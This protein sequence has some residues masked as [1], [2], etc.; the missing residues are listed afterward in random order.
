MKA[1]LVE[2]EQKTA[3]I[4]G[5]TLRL[6]FP[7]IDLICSDK[8]EP[9]LDLLFKEIFDFAII[10]LKLADISGFEFLKR[11]RLFSQVPVLAIQSGL[12]D[13]DLVRAID[14]GADD[15]LP[16][17]VNPIILIARAKALIRRV[18]GFLNR[19]E[20]VAGMLRLDSLIHKAYFKGQEIY[21]TR[22]E[23]IVLHHLMNNAGH[24]ASYR[25]LACQLWGDD[26][27][28]SNKAIRKCIDRLKVKLGTVA[29]SPELINERGVGFR[30]VP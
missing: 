28:G 19:E 6:P 21:L 3:E 11:M 12:E 7:D 26:Y 4:L 24:V 16:K 10:D 14:Y 8:G 2:S 17:P 23:N 22:T 13:I 30:L 18:N 1:L 15:C 29:A 20:T 5:S 9:G 25:S 27:P